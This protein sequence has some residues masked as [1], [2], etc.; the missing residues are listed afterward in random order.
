MFVCSKTASEWPSHFPPTHQ[1][2]SINTGTMWLYVTSTAALAE[3]T[4]L[5]SN[6]LQTIWSNSGMEILQ[7]C[8]AQ[9]T[10]TQIGTWTMMGGSLRPA[11]Q[12]L[13]LAVGTVPDY[14]VPGPAAAALKLLFVLLHSTLFLGRSSQLS[15][16]SGCDWEI[17]LLNHKRRQGSERRRKI[18]PVHRASPLCTGN[19]FT[20]CSFG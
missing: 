3:V 9:N 2:S 5:L 17:Q 16:S 19:L 20:L 12:N 6:H 8:S 11:G 14:G 4:W 1:L 13:G 18:N 7:M 10:R 15:C